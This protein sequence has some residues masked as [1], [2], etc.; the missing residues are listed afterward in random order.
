MKRKFMFLL[1]IISLLCVNNVFAD[2]I[3]DQAENGEKAPKEEI[4]SNILPSSVSKLN[5][6][7]GIYLAFGFGIGSVIQ[8]SSDFDDLLDPYT[9]GLFGFDRS[10]QIKVGYKEYLQTEY[11]W[12]WRNGSFNYTDDYL[13]SGETSTIEMHHSSEQIFIKVN[14]FAFADGNSLIN[15]TYLVYGFGESKGFLDDVDDGFKDGEVT[16][17]GVE[18]IPIESKDFLFLGSFGIEYE[19]VDYKYFYLEDFGGA[20]NHPSSAWCSKFLFSV[21]VGKNFF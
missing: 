7:T 17:Y 20:Y 9:F 19:T 12:S 1:F 4:K 18:M 14:P 6:P 16:S 5:P 11:R 2:D 3:M 13:I 10:L 15:K 21:G 8:G